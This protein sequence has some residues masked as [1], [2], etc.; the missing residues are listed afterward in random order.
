MDILKELAT[1]KDVFDYIQKEYPTWIVNILPA[2]AEEYE[3]LNKN[4]YEICTL[5]KQQPQKIIIVRDYSNENFLVFSE[6]FSS[7]G[8]QVR[9]LSEVQECRVCHNKALPTQFLFNKLKENEKV[10]FSLPEIWNDTC[11]KCL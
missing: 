11:Q 8:F 2:Y 7:T 1:M 6:L 9:T 10:K 5:S 4:W 3:D